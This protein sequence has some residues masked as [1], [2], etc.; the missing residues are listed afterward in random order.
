LREQHGRDGNADGAHHQPAGLDDRA[1]LDVA[2]E[3]GAGC[4]LE[5]IA[6]RRTTSSGQLRERPVGGSVKRRDEGRYRREA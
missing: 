3:R 2:V 4:A 6:Q 5:G 1:L